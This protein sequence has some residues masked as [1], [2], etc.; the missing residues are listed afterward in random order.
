M[1]LIRPAPPPE[2]PPTPSENGW[3][4]RDVGIIVLKGSA[5][6]LAI[7]A[8]STTAGY[9][10]Q[11]FGNSLSSSKQPFAASIGFGLKEASKI[12]FVVGKYAFLTVSV[13]L[14]ALYKGAKWTV[15]EGIPLA[16]RSISSMI[17]ALWNKVLVPIG[18]FLL[19]NAIWLKDHLLIP[20]LKTIGDIAIVIKDVI[21]SVGEKAYRY[22]LKPAGEILWKI[23]IQVGQ[24]LSALS[25]KLYQY[26]L[27]PLGREIKTALVNFFNY[28]LIPAWNGIKTFFTWTIANVIIP[29]GKLLKST[30]ITLAKG[31]YNHL[32]VP[33]GQLLQKLVVA[34]EATAKWFLK[35]VVLAGAKALYNHILAPLGS[36]LS[37]ALK[38][39]GSTITYLFKQFISGLQRLASA[40]IKKVLTPLYQITVIGYNRLVS[41]LCS[42]CQFIFK[43]LLKPLF[44]AFKTAIVATGKGLYSY[45]LIPISQGFL[46]ASKWVVESVNA[47]FVHVSTTW[48]EPSPHIFFLVQ[49]AS[50]LYLLPSCY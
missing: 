38:K 40:L 33:I 19:K 41:L 30:M 12:L 31:L 6:L 21:V 27:L 15:L 50:Q 10:F 17:Q 46:T 35:E 47:I 11:A 4:S 36:L 39:L 14:Y 44:W 34:V 5:T 37:E 29:T 22:V 1:I 48:H 28:I 25:K 7:A 45:V 32:I 13:P 18:Q 42:I 8:L 2:P 16:G 3:S 43:Y 26:V 23:A 49:S 20:I 9:G 24:L